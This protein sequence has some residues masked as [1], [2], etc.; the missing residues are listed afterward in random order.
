MA[1]KTERMVIRGK[2]NYAKVLGDPV[3]NYSKDGKEW[4]LD[5]EIDEFTEKEFKKAG[6]GDRVRRKDTYLD[7]RPYV[8]F[9]QAEYRRDGK[10]N[11]PIN[12]TDILGEP[13]D[14]Q[15]LIGNGSDVDV[16]FAVVDYGPGKKKGAYVRTVRVLKLVPY[17]KSDIP[18]VDENDPFYEEA[19]AA[20]EA[21]KAREAEQFRKDFGLESENEETPEE[22]V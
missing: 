7:G 19:Q 10:I 3:L 20:Q 8:T 17:A 5:V 11:D 4:K 15:R 21:R 16:T 9:K 1:N 14:Q 2:A 13:W 12:V 18:P 6:I 22:V